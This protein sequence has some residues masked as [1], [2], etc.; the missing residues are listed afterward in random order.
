MRR[1]EFPPT[2]KNLQEAIATHPSQIGVAFTF[3]FGELGAEHHLKLE[4]ESKLSLFIDEIESAGHKQVVLLDFQSQDQL[5]RVLAVLGMCFVLAQFEPFVLFDAASSAQ[6]TSS[7]EDVLKK[8]GSLFD[9]PYQPGKPFNFKLFTQHLSV[10]S[11]SSVIILKNLDSLDEGLRQEIIEGMA[12]VESI[13]ILTSI[14]QSLSLDEVRPG[15]PITATD[16]KLN[17]KRV[18]RQKFGQKR[19]VRNYSF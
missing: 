9:A 16:G 1:I 6:P 11:G 19:A 5:Q 15:N 8:L 17:L 10:P 3:F 13:V 18:M 14:N 4:E 12:V 2:A 7:R